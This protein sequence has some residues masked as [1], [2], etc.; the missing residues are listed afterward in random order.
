MA[1]SLSLLILSYNT[2]YLYDIYGMETIRAS[3]KT[4][5]RFLVKCLTKAVW[6]YTSS[7]IVIEG[8]RFFAWKVLIH[9]NK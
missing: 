7:A 1:T 6:S 9:P 4:S 2:G 5:R 8:I 3:K